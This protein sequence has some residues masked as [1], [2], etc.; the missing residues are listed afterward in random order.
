MLGILSVFFSFMLSTI[1][2]KKEGV[3]LAVRMLWAGHGD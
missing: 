3:V 1:G 2:G